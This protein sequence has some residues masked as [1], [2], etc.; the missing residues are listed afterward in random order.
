[1]VFFIDINLFFKSN[2]YTA[3]IAKISSITVDIKPDIANTFILYKINNKQEKISTNLVIVKFF[4]HN[5]ILYKMT[6]TVGNKLTS[7]F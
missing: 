3:I 7:P 4:C 6:A 1:M 2:L 5:A